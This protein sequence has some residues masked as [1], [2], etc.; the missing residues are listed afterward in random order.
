MKFKR[1]QPAFTNSHLNFQQLEPRQLLAALANGQEVVSSFGAGETESFEFQVGQLEEIDI[2]VGVV[3][4]TGTPR[5]TVLDPTGA[6]VGS[7]VGNFEAQL[8]FPPLQTGTYT[9]IVEEDGNNRSLSYR[10][11]AVAL[12]DSP[13]LIVGRDRALQNGEEANPFVPTGSF[14]I[15][16][17]EVS[18]GNLASVSIGASGTTG[19]PRLTIFGPDG[20]EVQTDSDGSV[21]HEREEFIA[22]QSGTYTAVVEESGRD[23][24]LFYS[25]R[26]TTQPNSAQLVVGR[27]QALADTAE[28]VSSLPTGGFNIYPFQATVGS[29]VNVSVNSNSTLL[30]PRL[31]I[32][33]PNGIEIGSDSQSFS[34]QVSFPAE[35]TGVYAAVVDSTEGF[36]AGTLSIQA[37]GISQ[38]PPEI[39]RFQRDNLTD[40]LIQLVTRPDGLN[41]LD[42]SFNQDVNVSANDFTFFNETTESAV[43]IPSAVF[44]QVFSYDPLSFTATFDLTLLSTFFPSGLYRVSAPA[45]SITAVSDGRPLTED[46]SQQVLVAL[47][48]DANLDGRVDVLGDGFA[49]VGNLGTTSGAT[50][51]QGDFN[52]DGMVNVLNDGFELIGNLGQNLIPAGSSFAQSAALA[53]TT[54]PA[55]PKTIVILDTASEE[56]DEPQT[57]VSPL[58]AVFADDEEILVLA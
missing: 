36:R 1:R 19:T 18:A 33:N 37:T 29:Q 35:V 3:G 28:A 32:F 9:V 54:L 26:A 24:S 42:V 14:N 55:V 48:G 16:P 49:L 15:H 4:T 46:F 47:P 44:P 7:D 30:F 41:S 51:Q 13:Q 45:S 2:S 50:W 12:A 22:F 8:K 20:E 10:I 23:R 11:R 5:L 40:D 38:L 57:V 6:P 17:F 27:D 21:F 39:I 25:I 58:D 53:S 43:T 34:A 56:D 52:G 31:T